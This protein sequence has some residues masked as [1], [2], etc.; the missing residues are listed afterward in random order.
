MDDLCVWRDRGKQKG[1]VA[2]GRVP[3]ITKH[4][5]RLFACEVEHLGTLRNRFRKLELPGIDSNQIIVTPGSGGGPSVGRRAERA[6]V[7]IVYIRLGELIP[8]RS[9]R[10]AW[11]S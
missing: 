2:L 9:L 5:A 10:K 3:L 1:A 11:P 8:E 4:R 7:D 6:K